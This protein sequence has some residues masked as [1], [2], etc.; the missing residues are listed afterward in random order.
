LPLEVTVAVPSHERPLRLRWLLNALEEQT[1]DAARF[2]VVVVHDSGDDTEHM[3]VTHPLAETGRLRHVRLPPGTGTASRQRNVAWREARADLVAFTDDDCRPAP[4]WLERLLAGARANPG[5]F[6]Q[7]RTMPDPLEIALLRAPH[8]RTLEVDPPTPYVPT[9]NV[10][11]PRVV[12]ERA[13]GFLEDPDLASGEDTDLAHR[14]VEA[15]TTQAAAPDAVVFHAVEAVS[16]RARIRSIGRWSDL[17]YVAKR[18]PHLRRELVLGLFWK[19]SHPLLLL[20]VAGAAVAPWRGLALLAALPYA[21]HL[22]RL[23]RRDARG[24]LRFALYSP[25][26]AVVDAAEV[27]ALARGSLRHG[28]PIL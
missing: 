2:E 25:G 18:H 17:A 3:I 22:R 5:A 21:W 26:R 14:A 6:V 23:E 15:G 28:E 8:A 27:A 16:L 24:W 13:D 9:C 7:G 12:L 11:Y 1:L 10:L 20:A 19:R 4:D